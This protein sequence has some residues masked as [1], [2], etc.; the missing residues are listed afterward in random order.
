MINEIIE[1][2]NTIRESAKNSNVRVYDILKLS[3]CTVLFNEEMKN[4]TTIKIGGRVPVFVQ[5]ESVDAACSALLLLKPEKPLILGNGSNILV[6]DKGLDKTVFHFGK[7]LSKIE[8]LDDTN[9]R[10]YA[11]TKLTELCNAVCEKG[12]TGLEF[13]Y[14]IPGTVGGA[15][16]MNAGAFD[17]EVADVLSR[18][19][20]LAQDEDFFDILSSDELDFG[21]RA[22]RF[23]RTGETILYA[24]F[25]LKHGDK[26]K[27]RAKMDDFMNR[28]Q[29]NQP[30]EYPSAGS[31]FR[32]P[33]G[34]FAGQL[35]EESGL[36]GYQIGGAKVSEKHAGFIINVDHATSKDVLELIKHIQ[37][38]VLEK[39][40]V[41]LETEIKYL[42]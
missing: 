24:D 11:G 26:T 29:T 33:A 42:K 40:G 4:H 12:L 28:R 25:A 14:G 27:I 21:Y 6:D 5:P 35:I 37:E 22:S 20:F 41:T 19:C 2:I 30:L 7:S 9:V 23:Q 36:K 39:Y 32:R 8:F 10:A 16:Y 15:V 3:G 18:V 34:Y 1:N 38:V 13:A 31:V 17:G